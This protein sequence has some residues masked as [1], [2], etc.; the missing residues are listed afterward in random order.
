MAKPID[1]FGG[2]LRF[3][4]VTNIIAV[5]VLLA[6]MLIYLLATLASA[7]EGSLVEVGYYGVSVIQVAISAVLS[8]LVLIQ[9]TK[10]NR[11]VPEKIKKLLTIEVLVAIGCGVV[12]VPI[13]SA[14]ENIDPEAVSETVK[15]I[16]QSI[17]YYLIW[18]RYFTV[19][20][21]VHSVF[22][23]QE[24]SDLLKNIKDDK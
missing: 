24:G 17:G 16:G 20:E 18:S 3:F 10:R 5:V 19:S 7:M 2:W 22:V 15:G 14:Y 6:A 13:S 21:R 23:R 4:Q 9:L 12:L 8:V 1:E 11:S